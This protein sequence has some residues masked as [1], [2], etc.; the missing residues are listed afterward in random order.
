[1]PKRAMIL[2]HNFKHI[3]LIISEKVLK[4]GIKTLRFFCVLHWLIVLNHV[5]MTF[6]TQKAATVSED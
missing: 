2:D 1:M 3:N 5:S 4:N 6:S